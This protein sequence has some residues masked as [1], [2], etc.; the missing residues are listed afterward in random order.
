VTHSAENDAP[1]RTPVEALEHLV[2]M[3]E[4]GERVPYWA[5]DAARVALDGTRP[6]PP[7]VT[8]P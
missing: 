2:I 6:I 8:A 1:F 4:R 5:I 3:L 7:E